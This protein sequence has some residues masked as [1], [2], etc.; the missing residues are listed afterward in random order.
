VGTGSRPWLAHYDAGVPSSLE[1]YPACTLL[2]YISETAAA[3]PRHP[4]SIFH[5]ARLTYAELE[6]ASDAL[7][8]GLVNLG[9][10]PGDRVALILP[11]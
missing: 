3:R 4:A 2:R 10:A 11:N 9:V 5:G 8:A 6:R 7:A 1:P